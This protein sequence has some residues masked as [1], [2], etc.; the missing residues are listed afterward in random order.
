MQVVFL[1]EGAD[2][3][4]L[5]SAYGITLLHPETKILLPNAKSS[6]FRYVFNRFKD[7]FKDKIIPLNEVHSLSKVFLVDMNNI[8]YLDKKLIDLI[9]ENTVIEI[10]DHHPKSEIHRKNTILHI[11]KTGAA[12]TIVVEQIIKKQIN[13]D[14]IDAT[15]LAFGIYEDTGS[16][17]YNLTTPKDL[18]VAAFL[19]EKG[20]DLNE[21]RYII[22]EKIDEDKAKI[23]EQL[24]EN[25]HTLIAKDKKIIVTSAYYDKYVSDISA[26]FHMIKPFEEADAVFAVINLKGKIVI[27]GRSKTQ[28]IDA[29]QILTFFGGG[30]HYAAASANVKGLTTNEVINI[31][32]KILLRESY[33]DLKV[34]DIMSKNILIKRRSERIQDL[35]DEIDDYPFITVVDDDQ[36]FIGIVLQKV[37]KDA[38]KHGVTDITLEN[39]VI[40]DIITLSPETTVIEAE[41]YVTKYSQDFFLVLEEGYPIGMVTRDQIVKSVHSQAFQTEKDVFISRERVKPKYVDYSKK[42]KKYFP[43]K[44]IKILQEI[45]Q[46][47]K[48][49]NFKVYIVGGVV[50]DIVMNKKSLDIDIIVEGDAIQLVKKFGKKK[51]L[52]FSVFEEFMTAQI[53]IDESLKLDFATARKESYDYPGAYPKVRKATLKE[54]LYRRDFTINTLAIEITEGNFG[55]LIDYFNGLQDIK[56]RTIRILHQ[57]SFIEDP[58]R[59][60]RALRFAGRLNFKLG[61][62]TE[63]L[64]KLAVDQNLLLTAPLGRINLE[65]N[66]TFNE[67]KTVEILLLMNKYKILQTLIPEFVLD[68]R[69]EEILVKIRDLITSFELFMNFKVNRPNL[70]L[71]SLMYHL[72]LEIS[73]EIL[74]KYYFESSIKFFNEYFE[75]KEIFKFIP[76]KDSQLYKKIKFI[77]KNLLIFFAASLDEE[78]S[79][80]ILKIM[81]K[82]EEK[83]LIISGEDLK[84]L[85]IPPSPKYKIILDD[86]FK[87]YLD[88]EIKNKEA[89]INYVKEKYIQNNNS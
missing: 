18:Q 60:L 73:S 75:Q 63:K 85:G 39:F 64:L 52:Q 33:S 46:T 2:L 11:E 43:E 67:E 7:R 65:M 66:L 87:K 22:E 37:I 86:V 49:L 13:I 10:F 80:R 15:I 58:I 47:A 14:S 26:Y 53:K 12:T 23:I 44:I 17:T 54:D 42:L 51:S 55:V 62:T 77:D 34:K 38:I 27:I 89:A 68:E 24:I 82:E 40:E 72:P 30:G 50:R 1:G 25:I 9:N 74:R 36:K 88:N 4:A 3:D 76:E 57:L 45:G 21:I 84:K 59:I 31:L 5:S 29:G 81:K 32:E 71:L 6:S 83:N 28:Q 61:K 8:Y 78:V 19:L 35:K 16:F 41:E 79:E 70:Y 20:A 56:D 69:R 48:E